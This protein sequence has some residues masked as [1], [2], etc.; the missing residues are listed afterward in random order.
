MNN[1]GTL[2]VIVEKKEKEVLVKI[3]DT[4]C[5]IVPEIQEK[6]F[7]PFFTTKSMGEGSGLGL[8][9]VRQ[10][11]KHHNGDIW[12]ESEPNNTTFTVSLPL[13]L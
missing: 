10:I 11:L 9:I 4:G 8:D 1:K 2:S 12:V 13:N 7:E 3:H 5:G 6:I